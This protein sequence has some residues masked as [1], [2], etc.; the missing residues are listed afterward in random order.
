MIDCTV[1]YAVAHTNRYAAKYLIYY[2]E[3]GGFFGLVY[4]E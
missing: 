3:R 4:A 1:G 2:V